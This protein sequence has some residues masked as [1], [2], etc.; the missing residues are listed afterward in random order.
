MPGKQFLTMHSSKGSSSD[1]RNLAGISPL[2][3]AQTRVLDGRSELRKLR[4]LCGHL[5]VLGSGV[6]LNRTAAEGTNPR[7]F[8]V[9]K[10]P[11]PAVSC[12]SSHEILILFALPSVKATESVGSLFRLLDRPDRESTSG[13]TKSEMTNFT[14][15][16]MA[17]MVENMETQSAASRPGSRQN[18]RRTPDTKLT[19]T[20][21]P[22]L[23]LRQPLK[24]RYNG[25][26]VIR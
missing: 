1:A 7:I 24:L 25:H 8:L 9:T 17:F 4:R 10:Q 22:Q 20:Q 11:L 3:L 14:C 18:R 12:S 15:H 5:E 16:D 2:L 13:K 6:L 26:R 23:F 19:Q 21:I